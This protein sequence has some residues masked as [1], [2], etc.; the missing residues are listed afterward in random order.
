[1]KRNAI[2]ALALILL[3]PLATCNKDSGTSEDYGFNIYPGTVFYGVA[4][5]AGKAHDITFAGTAYDCAGGPTCYAIIYT[6]VLNGTSYVGIAVEQET[7]TE[8]FTLKIWYPGSI[9]TSF[10]SNSGNISLLS[11]SNG[12]VLVKDKSTGV[13]EI[14]TLDKAA[15]CQINFSGVSGNIYTIGPSTAT[16]DPGN[17]GLTITSMSALR[18]L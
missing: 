16:F 14:F 6:S 9:P 11:G 2:A 1:M 15:A 10:P 18:A 17:V 13:T 3:L 7:A 5:D 8:V 4:S 12:K